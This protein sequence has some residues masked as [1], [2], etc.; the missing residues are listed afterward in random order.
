MAFCFGFICLFVYTD[1]EVCSPTER[2][3]LSGERGGRQL[4]LEE[5]TD[6]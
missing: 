4:K 6:V 5:N 1:Y 3:Q 2:Q